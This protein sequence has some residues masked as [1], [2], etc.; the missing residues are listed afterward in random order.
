MY[1]G[2]DPAVTSKIK[3]VETKEFIYVSAFTYHGDSVQDQLSHMK[4]V[5]NLASAEILEDYIKH[6][7]RAVHILWQI[8]IQ[9]CHR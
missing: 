1:H 7:G 4:G 3:P 5:W 2:F 6:K 8:C 9:I